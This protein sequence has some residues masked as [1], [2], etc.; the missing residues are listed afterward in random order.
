MK[1]LRG[2]SLPSL[3]GTTQKLVMRTKATQR[4][5]GSGSTTDRSIRT[6]QMSLFAR[7]RMCDRMY[8]RIARSTARKR[9]MNILMTLC[10]ESRP[11][12]LDPM[13]A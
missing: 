6:S 4:F 5:P 11:M 1:I 12:R 3:P 8:A 2:A 9:Y 13:A 10:T 7:K